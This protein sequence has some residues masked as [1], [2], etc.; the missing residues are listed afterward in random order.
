MSSLQPSCAGWCNGRIAL[1]GFPLIKKPRRHIKKIPHI[2][3]YLPSCVEFHLF[4]RFLILRSQ[5]CCGDKPY[6]GGIRF[7]NSSWLKQVSSDFDWF[8]RHSPYGSV[9]N[10]GPKLS[11]GKSNYGMA[12]LSTLASYPLGGEPTRL[13][14]LVRL[15]HI[16][17]HLGWS[18]MTH[19][20]IT[21]GL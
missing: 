21:M 12:F 13:D 20:P 5:T 18:N 17:S 3:S 14:L 6:F 2:Y 8:N 16:P 11:N 10:W 19:I 7:S 4:S 9:S 1:K 15:K